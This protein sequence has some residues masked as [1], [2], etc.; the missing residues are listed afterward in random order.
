MA[1][2]RDLL[3]A[4]RPV[5]N[6]VKHVGYFAGTVLV[7][8]AVEEVINLWDWRRRPAGE[9]LWEDSK[10]DGGVYSLRCSAVLCIA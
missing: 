5:V 2:N 6:T 7:I 10:I 1:V 4:Q 8:M 3:L 9:G